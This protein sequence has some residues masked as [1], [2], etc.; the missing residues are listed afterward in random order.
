MIDPDFEIEATEP[1]LLERLTAHPHASLFPMML[2]DELAELAAD[3]K[4]RGQREPI[5]LFEGQIL[6]GRNRYEACLRIGIEP[7]TGRKAHPRKSAR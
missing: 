3:M 6:D 7:K 5:R 2:S 4:E 1:R